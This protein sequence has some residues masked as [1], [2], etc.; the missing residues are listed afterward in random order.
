VVDPA[1]WQIPNL[2]YLPREGFAK[3]ERDLITPYFSALYAR[4]DDAWTAAIDRLGM[5]GSTSLYNRFPLAKQA[6]G[7]KTSRCC[8]PNTVKHL[9]L[10]IGALPGSNEDL[11]G[12][13]S[14]FGLCVM[15]PV[16]LPSFLLG[17][18][19]PGAAWRWNGVRV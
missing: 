17:N 19:T 11:L 9:G 6:T 13:L 5:A 16:P 14:E 15:E 3:L 2:S 1:A 12:G 8:V 10:A 4:P 18:I 7:K